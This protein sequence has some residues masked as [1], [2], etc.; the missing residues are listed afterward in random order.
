MKSK[1]MWTVKMIK[2]KETVYDGQF[3]FKSDAQ[4]RADQLVE[5]L[6]YLTG[7]SIPSACEVVRVL[8]YR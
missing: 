1:F 7:A 3:E 6:E 2:N 4:D 8:V 5:H